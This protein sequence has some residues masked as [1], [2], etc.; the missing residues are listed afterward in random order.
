MVGRVGDIEGAMPVDREPAGSELDGGRVRIATDHRRRAPRRR[1]TRITA[2]HRVRVAIIATLAIV[3][4][5]V[6]AHL[7][8]A[9]VGATAVPA[10][11]VAVVAHLVRIDDAVAA[12]G[13]DAHAALAATDA[14]ADRAA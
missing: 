2:I 13:G 7:E 8:L 10:R 14:T 5:A 1:R 12:A 11:G 6:A 4:D 9:A 3:D